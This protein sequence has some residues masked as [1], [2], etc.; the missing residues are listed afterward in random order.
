[1]PARGAGGSHNLA[2]LP[3]SRWKCSASALHSGGVDHRRACIGISI[4]VFVA[5]ARALAS[6]DVAAPPDPQGIYGGEP[7]AA[8]AWPSAVFLGGCTGT[9]VHPQVVIYAAHCGT[10]V[11]W[12]WFGEDSNTQEGSYV[13]V[14]FCSVI[15][16]GT[17]GYG[18]DFAVCKLAEPVTDVPIVPPL[19][20]C[21][22]D[23]LQPGLQTWL[24][25]FGNTDTG[26]FGTKYEV[27]VEL[28]YIENDEAFLGGNGLAPC[29]GDSGGPAYV[30]LP[31]SLD[32]EQSW[33][34]FGI[35]SWG[36]E[37]GG[38][39]FYSMMHN[40]ME[41]F[42]SETGIDVTPC[43]DANGTWN[44]GPDCH[45]FPLDPGVGMGAWPSCS[46]GGLSGA[47]ATCGDGAPD[48]GGEE[49]GSD[50]SGVEEGPDHDTGE[51]PTHESDD[52]ALS[53]SSDGDDADD[54]DG[55]STGFSD[56]EGDDDEDR[57]ALPPG[58]GLDGAPAAGCGCSAPQRAPIALVL[59]GLVGLTR[60]RP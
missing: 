53:G 16:G 13:G 20:G 45:S 40:G 58:H 54:D 34:V 12:A 29:Y 8:C 35:T 51:P 6:D 56:D 52:G 19:M 47:A 50:G 49:S 28:Q 57:P 39:G 23:V 9:L 38:G 55:D 46:A 1:M 33:R 7:A 22:T 25:G 42:E 31:A 37:C 10:S 2:R 59:V 18:N 21:E 48:P 44:P 43:H 27:A 17:P 4:A 60:R 36:G 26:G 30:Q 3:A 5:P 41:W 11:D 24:V 14:E 15:P 32:P